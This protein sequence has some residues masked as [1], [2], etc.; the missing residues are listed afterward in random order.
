MF[1]DMDAYFATVEQQLNP[2]LRHKP[3]TV[4]PMITDNTC[5]IAASYEAKRLG[6]KTGT[7]VGEAKEICPE[8]QIVLARPDVYVRFHHVIVMGC[9][10]LRTRQR[11][12]LGRRNVLPVNGR[13]KK[14][15]TH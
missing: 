14:T 4:V 11:N 2:A 10:I 12:S 15:A 5:C 13:R 8:L 6:I 1:V 7:A 9:R 3:I